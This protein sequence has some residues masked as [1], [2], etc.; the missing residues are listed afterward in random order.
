VEGNSS[1]ETYTG[2]IKA[3]GLHGGAELETHSGRITASFGEFAA[4]S[5]VDTHSGTVRLFLPAEAGFELQLDLDEEDLTVDEAFGSP[6]SSGDDRRT[7]NDG[8]P[9]FE[10]ES[11]SGPIEVRPREAGPSSP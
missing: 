3:T 11:F 10:L 6:T 4:P 7:Y 8:G 1:L 9:A 2:S 5:S